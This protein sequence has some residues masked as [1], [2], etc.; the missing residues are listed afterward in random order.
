MNSN[1]EIRKNFRDIRVIFGITIMIIVAVFFLPIDTL[2]CAGGIC[3]GYHQTG[4][5]GFKTLQY[6]FRVDDILYH[7]YKTDPHRVRR[8]RGSYSTH[9]D[10]SPVLH[11]KDGRTIELPL[12]FCY[13]QNKADEFL[14]AIKS[15]K[16]TKKS[17]FKF[18]F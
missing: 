15:K 13:N 11:L 2:I 6:Q 9:T 12:Q 7:T 3:K 14:Q 1:W 8:S 10:Y 5:I 17:N 4:T 16:Y 18:L